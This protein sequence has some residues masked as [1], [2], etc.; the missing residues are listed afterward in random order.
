MAIRLTLER[1]PRWYAIGGGAEI[2]APPATTVLIYAAREQAAAWLAEYKEAGAVVTRLGGQITGGLDVS[3]GEH[4]D[5][6]RRAFFVVALGE[7]VISDWRGIHTAEGAPLGFDPQYVA[8]LFEDPQRAETFLEVYIKPLHEVELE[9]NVSRPSPDGI[10]ARAGEK[11][12]A[13]AARSRAKPA[14]RRTRKPAPTT[15]MPR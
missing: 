14:R 4:E 7:L 12:T 11:S 15:R 13:T 6:V 2:F 5:S 10:S 3:D 1:E 8:A 9:G